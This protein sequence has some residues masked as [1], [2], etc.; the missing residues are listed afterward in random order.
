MPFDAP[1]RRPRSTFN[2]PRL[3]V[4]DRT[5][6]RGGEEHLMFARLGLTLPAVALLLTALA[7]PRTPAATPRQV[8]ESIRRAKEWLYGR[9]QRDGTWESFGTPQGGPMESPDAGQWGGTTA[10]ASYALLASGERPQDRRV[11]AAIN[12][13][14]RANLTGTYAIALRAQTWA[15][16]PETPE[17]RKLAARDAELL[18]N[19]MHRRRGQPGQGMYG[20]SCDLRR[21][22]DWWDHSNS[23]F[24]VLGMWACAEVVKEITGKYWSDVDA[25][26]R[27]DQLKDG[28]WCYING[29]T[30]DEFTQPRMSMTEAG[31]ATLFIT[32][33]FLT[34]RNGG[35][36]GNKRDAHIE[37]GMKWMAE[38]FREGLVPEAAP[39]GFDFWLYALYGAERIGVASGYKYF[40]K[41]DWYRDGADAV[42]AAQGPDG[43]WRDVSNTCFAIL[44]LVRGRAPVLMNKLSYDL[45]RAG[46]GAKLGNWNQRPRDAANLAHWVGKQTERFLNWQVVTLAGAPEDL[47]DAPILYLAG[48]QVLSFSKGETEKL[49]LFVEQGG[50]I[51]G[52][53]DCASKAFS[54]SFRRLG[55]EIAPAYEFRELPA[56]H[57]IYTV[58]QFQRANWK[59]KPSVLGLSNGA[60]E[61]M[62]LV[63]QADPARAWQMQIY[64]GKEELHQL[65]GDIFLYSV[66]KRDLRTKGESY[67]VT[68]HER[69]KALRQVRLARL[70]YAGNW[71][72]EPGGWRRLANVLHN[73]QW[74]DLLVTPVKLGEGKLDAKQFAVAHM[75]GTAA[76]TLRE[77]ER[78][79][80]RN[81]VDAG[82]VL[83]IDAAGGAADF[84]GSAEAELAAMF[85]GA[86]PAVLAPDAAVFTS[87][88]KIERFEYRNFARKTIGAVAA[89]RLRGI[90][91]GGRT[92]VFCSP[93]DLSVGLVGQP[94][95]GI[96]GYSPA[97]ATA[98]MSNI[99]VARAA[100]P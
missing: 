87:P 72:P 46:D 86:S 26:W 93:E 32:E 98:I 59:N 34:A 55:K 58:E 37:A 49:R 71:D 29:G 84:A 44:F 16:V 11:A 83:V 81:F 13:L 14:K 36:A 94:V 78:A 50:L 65:A 82:G 69:L 68:R 97:T 7:A 23:Q 24:A 12:F 64:G 42:L 27:R 43:S 17:V 22:A 30:I 77:V 96:I 100:G 95:D 47:H 90:T 54:D 76:F 35:C 67:V 28:S 8:E 66:D 38:H 56:D 63:P 20:Y 91:V 31:I 62:L 88:R 2:L 40:G 41:I 5:G 9:Q 6:R 4:R 53:A 80:L 73:E 25:A 99:V 45:D 15:L 75:T 33:D 10:I 48:D 60:R 18:F 1:P 61:L 79:E 74:T 92:A 19:G 57:P 39:G 52:N 70:E 3:A 85:P 51:L 89:P 21:G